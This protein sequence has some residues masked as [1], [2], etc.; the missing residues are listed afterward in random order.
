M[1]DYLVSQGLEEVWYL[2]PAASAPSEAVPLGRRGRVKAVRMNGWAE[3][4]FWTKL[5]QA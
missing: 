1:K 2:V 3:H 4:P 5:S